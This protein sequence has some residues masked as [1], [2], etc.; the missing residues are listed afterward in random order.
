MSTV[1]ER[2]EGQDGWRPLKKEEYD[3]C[4]S[5]KGLRDLNHVGPCWPQRVFSLYFLFTSNFLEGFL[6][7][8][9]QFD[10]FVFKKKSLAVYRKKHALGKNIFL[11][12]NFLFPMKSLSEKDT[13]LNYYY[14]STCLAFHALKVTAS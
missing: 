4:W 3:V 14:N 1:T 13:M 12:C 8:V 7:Q 6:L 11:M 10:P 5:Q 9:T 2:N